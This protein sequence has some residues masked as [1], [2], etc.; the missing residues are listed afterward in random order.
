M[1]FLVS[2]HLR[3]FGGTDYIHPFIHAL[4]LVVVVMLGGH[5]SSSLHPTWYGASVSLF[6]TAAKDSGNAMLGGRLSS[7]KATTAEAAT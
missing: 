5:L 1:G 4:C 3:T 7:I 6:I 2:L